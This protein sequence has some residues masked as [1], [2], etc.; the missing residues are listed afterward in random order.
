[1]LPETVIGAQIYI[2]QMQDVFDD[3][4][5]LGRNGGFQ[6]TP[7]HSYVD[8]NRAS[9]DRM[10]A[11]ATGLTDEALQHPVGEHWTVAITL[12]HLAWWDGR[13][14]GKFWT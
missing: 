6:M 9:T 12:V 14:S 7:D 5:R 10:R 2:N 8:L 1:M 4:I 11:L 13:V 3:W